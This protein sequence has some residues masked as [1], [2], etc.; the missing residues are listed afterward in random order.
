LL[1]FALRLDTLL[2][3]CLVDYRLRITYLVHV[4][5]SRRLR[6]RCVVVVTLVGVALLLL[7]LL[8]IALFVFTVR[9]VVVVVMVRSLITFALVYI[10]TTLRCCGF[11]AVGVDWTVVAALLLFTFVVGV[12]VYGCFVFPYGC[13][14][15][16]FGYVYHG[17]IVTCSL[18]PLPF[19]VTTVGC[20]V[21]L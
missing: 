12:V 13:Y 8:F 11:Y 17:S 20:L 7:L 18:P 16:L 15:R 14:G 6:V 3:C 2:H 5:C 1:P 4:H 9:F 10:V 21:G 19:A